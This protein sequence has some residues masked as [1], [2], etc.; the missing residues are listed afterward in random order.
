MGWPDIVFFNDFTTDLLFIF[1][2]SPAAWCWP[3]ISSL[4]LP[5]SIVFAFFSVERAGDNSPNSRCR[6]DYRRGYFDKRSAIEATKKISADER[7]KSN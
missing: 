4:E 5:S 3:I 2:A 1:H 7:I 6:L